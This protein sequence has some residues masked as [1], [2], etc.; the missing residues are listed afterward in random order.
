MN[1]ST[2]FLS[3][4]VTSFAMLA[5]PVE[6]AN[7]SVV[8]SGSNSTT[9]A[10]E[11][12]LNNYLRLE[13]HRVRSGTT[14]GFLVVLNTMP[15]KTRDGEKRGVF[16]SVIIGSVDWVTVSE[17]LQSPDCR[18]ELVKNVKELLGM[19]LI[20]IGTTIATASDENELARV[21]SAYAHQT[22]QKATNRIK[23]IFRELSR[24]SKGRTG[25]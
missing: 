15:A 11:S 7:I 14:D 10:V 5:G 9:P 2:R 4:F 3:V 25:L 21:L 1:S 12:A 17:S 8:G 23:V 19:D 16:G 18:G 13:G 6:A 20:L 22:I 24:T